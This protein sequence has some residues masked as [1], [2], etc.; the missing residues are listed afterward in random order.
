[1]AVYKILDLRTAEFVTYRGYIDMGNS[2]IVSGRVRT[3]ESRDAA[4]YGL[5]AFLH[6]PNNR[7]HHPVIKEYFE[8]V[9][10]ADA[11]L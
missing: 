4:E 10:V 5:L 1:M 11:S 6:F 7:H 8:I 9:E 3:F 2:S